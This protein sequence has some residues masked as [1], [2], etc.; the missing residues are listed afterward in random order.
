M[1]EAGA[2]AATEDVERDGQ[3]I[4]AHCRLGWVRSRIYIDEFDDPVAV[5]A[6]GGRVQ[7]DD[8][9]SAKAQWLSERLAYIGKHIG[10]SVDEALIVD[11][12]GPPCLTVSGKYRA[13]PIGDWL[14]WVGGVFVIF[15]GRSIG[16]LKRQVSI[17]RE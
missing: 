7:I 17:G 6:A 9:C 8:R 10:A 13:R 12:P 3:L 1:L 11:E 16:R 15:C 2:V 4:A 14:G 5:A